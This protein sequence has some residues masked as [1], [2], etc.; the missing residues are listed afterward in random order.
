MLKRDET[1]EGEEIPFCL[2]S[3]DFGTEIDGSQDFFQVWRVECGV[4]SVECEG[5]H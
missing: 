2:E 4:W 1:E 5:S 3:M